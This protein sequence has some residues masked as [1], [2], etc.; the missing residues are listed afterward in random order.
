[1]PQDVKRGDRNDDVKL[2]Q[3]RINLHGGSAGRPDGI[4]GKGT[5]RALKAF[6]ASHGVE[7]NGVCGEATWSELM[8]DPPTT[9]MEPDTLL[10][11]G[12][13]TVQTW[14]RY[15]GLLKELAGN[16]GFHPAAA[17]AVMLTESGGK[18]FG[19]DGAMI[20]RFEPHVFRR[21]VKKAGGDTELVA[22][23]FKD[24][25][26]RGNTHFWRASPV[27]EWQSFHGNQG[28]EWAALLFAVVV[29]GDAGWRSASY[30]LPQMMGFNHAACGYSTAAA[31]VEDWK[32]S[33]EA[34]IRGMFA[35]IKASSTMVSALKSEDF[36]TFASR[37]NGPG[38]KDEY[39]KLIA[40]RTTAAKSAGV[41]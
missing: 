19:S 39:G 24:D 22:Q 12:S 21:E 31:M 6:Q 13:R 9:G 1:M 20:V 10:S 27:G 40:A 18:A 29:G 30:G 14:N 26:W 33:A 36:V 35:F 15:G 2:M 34:Q 4:F 23:H 7:D 25:G 41:R 11:G 38:Q 8:A 17:V 3:E 16:M 32:S 37:Y 5:E 28:K